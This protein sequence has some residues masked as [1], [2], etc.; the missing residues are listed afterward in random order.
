MGVYGQTGVGEVFECVDDGFGYAVIVAGVIV[1]GLR[2]VLRGFGIDELEGFAI[3]A[4]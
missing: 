2:I 3:V 1:R 4:D